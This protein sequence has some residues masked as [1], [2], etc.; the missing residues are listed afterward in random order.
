MV[1]V[2]PTEVMIDAGDG[3]AKCDPSY[4]CVENW[5][6]VYAAMLAAAPDVTEE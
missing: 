6:A 4:G 3:T 5:H 2:E 1:P